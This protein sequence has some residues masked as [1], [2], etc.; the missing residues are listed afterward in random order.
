MT[1]RLINTP[2]QETERLTSRAMNVWG[3]NAGLI[4]HWAIPDL[5]D[6]DAPLVCRHP[7]PEDV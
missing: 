4:G 1:P 7:R 2:V 6:W 5:T 3:V